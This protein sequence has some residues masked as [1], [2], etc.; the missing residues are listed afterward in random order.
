MMSS[1]LRDPPRWPY[2][3]PCRGGPPRW[4]YGPRGPGGP[5][6]PYGPGGLGG[7]GGAIS[8]PWGPPYGP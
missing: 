1:Y 7:L 4:P 5:P 2:G 8:N 3:T 6:W